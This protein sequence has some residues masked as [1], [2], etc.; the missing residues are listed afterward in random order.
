MATTEDSVQEPDETFTVSLTVSNTTETVTATDTA[1]GTILDDDAPALTIGDASA[2]SADVSASE[3]DS[4][5]FTVRLDKAVQGGLTVTPSFTDVTATEGTDY[6]ENTAALTFAGNAG[7]TQTFTVATTEDSVQE[8]DET[9][10]VSLAVSNTTE[11]VTATDTAKGTILDDDAPALTIGDAS[12]G[13]ADVSASE[14][15][16]MTFTVRLDKAVQ[17]G[18]TVTPSFTDV[19]A[20]EGTDYTENTAAL[21]FAGNAGETQTFTV[22]TTE[23]SVQEPDETFTVSLTVSNTTETV[24]ATDTAKGTILDDDAPA[25]TIGDASA[26]SADVSAS[27]GDSMTFTV[28]LD[29]AVQGGLTVTPSFTDVTATEGTDYTE[30]TT[31]LTFAGTAGETKTF[32]VTT[33]E[34]TV[35]EPD[36]TFTVSLAVSNTTETVTATD[37][38]KGTILDDDA[39]ALTIGDGSAGSADVSASEGDS[40]TFTVRLDK[41][42]QGGLTVTPSFT[43]VTA[44]EGTDYTEN[45]TALTFAGT[46]GET[47]TFTVATTE[48]TDQEPDETFTVSL[49]VSNAGETV[50]A[51]DTAT[52][53]ILDDDASALTIGDASA[54]SADV[55]VSEGDSMTFTVRLDREV[56]GG[57]TVTPSFTDV[58]ATEG[59][60]Y[61]ENTTALTFA[62]TAG[63]TK[64]FTVTTTEDS[65]EE[66]DE[67]FTVSLAVSGTTAKVTATDTATGTI[68]DD[69]APALTI[70]DASAGSADVSASEGDSMTFTVRLDKAVSGGFT[71]TPSFT[72]VTA[73]EGTD[74]TE[75]TAALTFAGTAGETKTFTV[76]T[77]EDT[78]AE[79]DETFTVS[80][81]VSGTTAK[82]TATDTATGTIL[83]DDAPALTIG[84]ASAGSADVSASEG[85]SMTFTVR[86]DKAVSGGFTVTPSFTDVTATEGTDYT[87]NTAALTFAGTAGETKTF[88]VTTTEDSV[89]EPD[90]TFTVSLAVSGTTAKVT[91]TDTATGTILDDDAPALTIGDASAG[92]ADVS[93]SEGDSMTFTVR[94]DK[95]VQGGLTVTPSFTD[96]TATEGTDY[97]ENTAA[98]TFAGNAGE[99][100]TFTVAT[101]EDTDQ[102]PDETFTVSLAVSGTTAKVTATDTATGTILDDDAPALTIGDA[103]A[104][105]A[106]VS[107]SEG[108][109]MTFTV[110]LDKAVQGGLTVTPSFTDVTATEGTDYTENTA[111]LTFAGN[112]GETQTFTV[113]TTEDT[114]QEPD[115]T[116]TVSLA[117]SGTT[118]KVTATDTATG[119]I[120]D[121]D[122]PALTIGDGSAGS[123]DVSASEGDSM[124][125][126]V[127][128]DKAVSGGFTVTPSF[129]DVTATEGTDYTENTA[130]L[131]FAGTAGETQTFTVATTEDTDE[132]E[133]ETFTV[134]LAVSNAGETVT[135]RDTAKGTILDDDETAPAVTISDGSAS[136]GDPI[137]FTVRLDKA[138][139]DSFTVTPS[140]TDGNAT[141]GTDYTENT[142]GL[143]FAGNAGET[144]TF[145]VAT[146][147]DTDA[148]PDETFTVSLA[149]S[150]TTAT[151]T[152]TDTAKGTILDDGDGS[153]SISLSIDPGS[154]DEESG[155]K[156]LTVRATLHGGTRKSQTAV[157][158]F[159]DGGTA[160]PDVDY[161]RLSEF[162]I[163]IPKGSSSGTAAVRFHP[164]NDDLPEDFETVEFLGKVLGA[165]SQDLPENGDDEG[166]LRATLTLE[167]DD[168]TAGEDNGPPSITIWTDRLGYLID[169]PVRLY[170]DIDPHGDSRKYTVFL[171]LESIDTGVRRYLAPES[172]Y[173]ELR[174]DVVDQ[175][176]HD[177]DV[178]RARTL[179]RVDQELTWEGQM[180]HAGLW[181]FVA[182]LRSP[183]SAQVLK[184]AYAK[185]VVPQ[186]GFVAL[187]GPDT[188][189]V[190]TEDTRLTSDWV[191]KLRNQLRVQNGATLEIDAGTLIEAWGPSAGITVQPGGRIVVRGRREAPVVMTCSLPVGQRFPGCWGGLTILGDVSREV[192][193]AVEQ[194]WSPEE[195]IPTD[196]DG[197]KD[198]SGAIRYLRVEFAGGAAASGE[199]VAGLAFQGVGS[200]TVIDR[201]QV[202]A[203]ATDGLAF[204]GGAAHC[205]HCV[206]SDAR[207]DSVD[208]SQG[209]QGS[210]QYLYVQQGPQA[211]SAMRGNSNGV[212]NP[213]APTFIN[214]TLVGGYNV[215]VVGGGAGEPEV[216]RAGSPAGGRRC[217]HNTKP[218]ER[219]ICRLR[220]RRVSDELYG[221]CQ[222]LGRSDLP[223]QRIPALGSV[224]SPSQ[225]RT[226]C[227]VCTGRPGSG[228]HSL[229]GQ[230]G[231]EAA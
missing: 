21:T 56:P 114:D 106:D 79:P 18:L 25:L 40:M 127:R 15:D 215:G 173:P 220:D 145:A 187:N 161:E 92:S 96:V 139:P 120:L 78:D 57:L 29:K 170:R 62:G 227:G 116:F 88:T 119:T 12:A 90:E 149:V 180:S 95:A 209:W 42:V 99:T 163:R 185:F 131:T 63:E 70:G 168:G 126:T 226:L 75:N 132:E 184:R 144:H 110:R 51:T 39:P 94:L 210:A 105:S 108:D 129:T 204:R 148:E 87:E 66:P 58:T 4:M 46:A 31:A 77:T 152:A 155:A 177:E 183:G 151:V 141:K 104:G 27:E 169:E 20:T 158:V 19:T 107:A 208:W 175:Y 121:D 89:E 74:Y 101:T 53:T 221:R 100:Q 159:P 35:Q 172:T 142:A 24:T 32:T 128:L 125:F 118:A 182:E 223:R 219:R 50:T 164:I 171:Y 37:T 137:T 69:D 45:T 76:T 73:T 67:T 113:A 135:A 156:V 216:D 222:Q 68:L 201:V 146:T 150:E 93:A 157:E 229:R 231:P 30:N 218:V 167:D 198:S 174:E 49:T 203:S 160:T 86:L 23:D 97:T 6:T 193:P 71:V 138:V 188:E 178:W 195:S 38:A 80:L 196:T 54:G 134:S 85:D 153:N 165:R 102:E 91:A 207:L 225:I 83:D 212:G 65:V 14:G 130:A 186:N 136:E 230:S 111:A 140:F 112:A 72:D 224:T 179:Q 8:P 9:F 115:E 2:G 147:E 154:V 189:R 64:T 22:A 82:V 202:H 117:V 214:V 47:K 124:T 143:S 7:E 217:D 84:D 11:T 192:D 81:A 166:A 206:S 122:A 59:T 48:D 16:S 41:A 228:E 33:T 17:G 123:A 34:D 60:D 61:T 36:E 26:G 133:D 5:T 194:A 1:K 190:L 52:G 181:H 10:T 211:A 199:P 13:S 205:S 28:R 162:T 176:G 197:L 55:S 109:S 213:S 103:S 3:G 98:L 191:Y 200:R 43:D 44:T